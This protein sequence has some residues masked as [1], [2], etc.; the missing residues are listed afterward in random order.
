MAS[1]GRLENY[2]NNHQQFTLINNKQSNLQPVKYGV[3]HGSVLGPLLFLIYT[4]A[5]AYCT[6]EENLTCL[7]TDDSNSF[8]SRDTPEEL[9][10]SMKVVLTEL[11]K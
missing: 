1:E 6:K 8:I 5:I 3:P 9:K 11:F 4:N 2:L 10:N 7:F